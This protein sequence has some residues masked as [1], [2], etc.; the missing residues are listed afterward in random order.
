MAIGSDRND[1]D[2]V[3]GRDLLDVV[4]TCEKKNVEGKKIFWQRSDKW[5]IVRH[6][7]EGA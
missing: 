5:E 7:E 2:Q 4:V 6:G 1:G 3:C